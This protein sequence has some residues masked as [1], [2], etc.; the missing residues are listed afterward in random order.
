MDNAFVNQELELVAKRTLT[1]ITG[2]EDTLT[3]LYLQPDRALFL[4][5]NLR[6]ILKV[7][8]AGKALQREYDIGREL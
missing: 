5:E 2:L 7:Y 1:R 6:I 3:P 8:M 4:A